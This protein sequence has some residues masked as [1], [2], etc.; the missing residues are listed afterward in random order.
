VVIGLIL[1]YLTGWILL[2]GIVA[3][4]VG[5]NILVTGGRL[6]HQSYSRLMDASD[7]QLLDRIAH[8]L[9]ANRQPGWINIHQLRAW[10][11]GRLVHID[12]HLV[13]PNDAILLD[14]HNEAKALETLLI[15][16]FEGNASVLVHTDPCTSIECP[17]CG[18]ADCDQRA[19]QPQ[20]TSC[21]W[22]RHHLVNTTE[23][24]IDM[25]TDD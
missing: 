10:R 16:E 8:L 17:V 25:Q 1:V 24:Q 11:A 20:N 2:D 18:R 22:T 7:P 6:V 3:C 9:E 4:L 21:P 19:H 12:L 15:N 14:A 5:V 13:L 23:G